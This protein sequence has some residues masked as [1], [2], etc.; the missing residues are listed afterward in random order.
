MRCWGGPAILP[1]QVRRCGAVAVLG[2]EIARQIGIALER[3]DGLL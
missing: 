2:I 1:A 3:G